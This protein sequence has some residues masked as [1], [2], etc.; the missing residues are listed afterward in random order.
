MINP[1]SVA[2]FSDE[3][4]K[5]AVLGVVMRPIHVVG[6]QQLDLKKLRAAVRAGKGLRQSMATS[7][8]KQGMS[9]EA[10]AKLKRFGLATLAIGGG[11]AAGI[12]AAELGI[13][14]LKR[15]GGPQAERSVKAH[16]I[17]Y[18]LPAMGMIAAP[19][20]IEAAR[21]MADKY[22]DE[23]EPNKLKA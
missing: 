16:V 2:A 1:V 6:A 23:G 8:S 22:I 17:K 3:M 9:D 12:G 4:Q 19:L 10:K 15:Y 20:A 5:I 7:L 13:R 21:R 14:A 11:T 18:G